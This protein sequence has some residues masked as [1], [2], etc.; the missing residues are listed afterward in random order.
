[1]TR[2]ALEGKVALITGA[3]RGQGE[4]EA[5]RFV[6]EG[7]KVVLADVLDDEGEAVG[8][9][10]SATPPPTGTSTSPTRTTGRPR[11][12]RRGALRPG[13]DPRQQRRHPRL[14]PDPQA[15][16]RPSSAR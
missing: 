4:A 7:A 5:R 8:R 9:V 2:A 3:A 12:R 14:Q 11:R 16:R 15:G 13:H 6:A 10:D 1:M